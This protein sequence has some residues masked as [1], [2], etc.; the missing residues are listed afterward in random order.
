MV[1]AGKRVA[2][3]E[4]SKR[5]YT[6]AW[7]LGLTF[8]LYFL[9][10][11]P[12]FAQCAVTGSNVAY[13]S[14]NLVTG[15]PATTTGNININCPG[16]LGSFPYLW[17]CISIGVGTNSVSVNNRT[18]KS[19]ANSLAYQ[20]YTDSAYTNIYPFSPPNQF[21]IPYSNTTGA[22]A[23]STVYARI[24]SGQ[25]TVPPGAYTDSYSGVSQSLVTGNAAPTLP[26]NCGGGSIPFSFTVSATVVASCVVSGNT[27][28]FG[29]AGVLI[30]NV[31]ATSTVS[32]TCS[33]TTPYNI[34]LSVGSGAGATVAVRKMT[35]GAKTINYSL[36]TN[37]GRTT[38][39]GNTIGVDALS[40]TGAGT[41]QNLTV[42]GRVPPQT[43]PAPGAFS[44]TIVITVTY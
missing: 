21:S 5:R 42:Y 41:G 22:N 10:T 43:T 28:N 40:G 35:S 3:K 15:S 30:A 16:G 9:T 1:L 18:M 44:D 25:T 34:G 12:V 20:L 14:V 31:D 27:L 13:G 7:L 23:N 11:I 37:S 26:G 17:A 8:G 6:L 36:Y 4:Y 2:G 32:A 24:V 38:L 29:T 19:G 39:W 33:Y